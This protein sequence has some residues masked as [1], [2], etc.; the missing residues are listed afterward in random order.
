MEQNLGA[1]RVVKRSQMGSSGWSS[2]SVYTLESGKKV[3]VKQGRDAA[4]FKGEALGLQAMY[5]VCLA[6]HH[7]ELWAP[8]HLACTCQRQACMQADLSFG[9]CGCRYTHAEDT[10]SVPP[11]RALLGSRR[12]HSLPAPE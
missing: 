1:G 3:F 4:M 7:I 12:C 2:A 8:W 10:A 6:M 5:G 9:C 11:W